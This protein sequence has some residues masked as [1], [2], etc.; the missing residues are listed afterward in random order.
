MSLNILIVGAGVCGP[1]L[2]FFLQRSNPDHKITVIERYPAL[3]ASGQQIDLKDQ[4]VVV[5]KKMGLYD[6][7]KARTVHETGLNI[8]DARGRTIASFGVQSQDQAR[9]Y[10]LTSE[11]EVLRGDLVEI[12]YQASIEQDARL[13]E[14]LG[15]EAVGG[16]RY[17]FDKTITELSQKEDGDGDGDGDD[18]GVDVTFSDGSRGRYDL[19]VAADGQGSRT[20]RL[21]FGQE[22]SDKCFHSLGVHIAF[23]SLP[24]AEG[25]GS[26]AQMYMA[27]GRFTQT[28]NGD[29]PATG[30]YFYTMKG[31]AELRAA[32]RAPLER[33]KEVWRDIWLGGGGGKGGGDGGD[34]WETK[35][36][37]EGMMGCDDF[38]ALEVGQVK[39][40]RLRAGRVVLLG[41]AAHAPSSFTGLGTSAA[42]I[43]AYILAGELAK[44]RA[45]TQ[46]TSTTTTTTTITTGGGKVGK[47][48]VVDKALEAYQENMR[49]PIREYQKLPTK[50]LGM[51]FPTS[52]LGMWTL[53]TVLWLASSLKIERLFAGGEEAGAWKVPEYPELKLDEVEEKKS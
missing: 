51:I 22:A 5:A 31:A 35:R 30:V 45:Q 27:P 7:I 13:T 46:T 34:G 25:E 42:L 24:R 10:T 3:R 43:G 15:R 19:V 44:A 40:D 28:R 33:R 9:S 14:E 48:D 12:F 32:A 4:G 20:R 6:A 37:V 21:A 17:E 49:T 26:M 39:M 38:Y 23:F 1:A 52:A 50:K 41:D 11:I 16:L 2:A 36:L 18:K 53:R 8:V 47:G 29:R